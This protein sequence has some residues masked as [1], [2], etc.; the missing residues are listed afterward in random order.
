MSHSGNQR[1]VKGALEL[2]RLANS[3]SRTRSLPWTPPPPPPPPS[4]AAAARDSDPTTRPPPESP[5][6]TATE[7]HA[8]PGPAKR[9]RPSPTGP[10]P[11]IQP[12]RAAQEPVHLNSVVDHPPSR[13]PVQQVHEPVQPLYTIQESPASIPEPE[14]VTPPAVRGPPPPPSPSLAE[15]KQSL[16]EPDPRI[17]PPPDT[18]ASRTA[19]PIVLPEEPVLLDPASAPSSAPAATPF[20]ASVSKVPSSR[21]GRLLHYGGLAASLGWG[22]ASE[23]VFRRPDSF[24]GAAAA[25]GED[26]SPAVQQKPRSLLMSEANLERLVSK[27][28]KMRGAALKLG[29]FMSIQDTKQL[30][31]QLEAILQ[32]VQNSA[33]YMPEWQT[34]S[35]LRDTLGDDWRTHFAEFEMRPFAAASIGQVHR[36]KLAADSPLAAEYPGLTDLAVKVQFPGV[37][38]SIASD[39]G[40]MRWLLVASAALPRG[41]YLDNSLRVM[42][43]E[44]E[45]ECDYVREAECGT[46]MRAW[47]DQSTELKDAFAVPRVVPQLSG[48]MVL[49]TEL[50]TGRPLKDVLTLDQ[51]KRDWIGKRILQLC[52][53]E[54]FEFRLMQ[55][56]P[57]WSNFLYNQ[58]TGKLELIDFGATREYTPEFMD[59]YGNLLDAAI[60]QDRE[61]AIR[62]SNELGY[63]TGQE[64]EAMIN[65]HLDS[66]FALATPFRPSSPSPFPFG[67]LGPPITA[68]IRAQIPV[69]LRERLTPPPEETY[70]L[71]RKLS[72]AF[73]LCERLASRVPVQ[74]M[75]ER[76]RNR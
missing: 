69:M 55:T 29:Q 5:I 43:R 49:T 13:P 56:D 67:T 11:P 4:R 33:N 52:M 1:A 7:A 19:E 75:Y 23:A 41:L 64:S 73:L 32:R 16:V 34:E 66:L 9:Q 26:G 6:A 65:A 57:N 39:L 48:R 47:V 21:F 42:G 60:R 12:I 15:E 44:L 10:P 51:D 54:L 20:N 50:M 76:A 18:S 59:V 63:F 36:A 45:D 31:P 37:R 2:L 40:T 74:E 58:S 27:L 24:A 8:Q 28:G 72:G 30:P 25:V 3:V 22:M 17:V 14:N 38:E 35:V 68:T 71:N 53:H 62:Y 46:R 70:S 61:P